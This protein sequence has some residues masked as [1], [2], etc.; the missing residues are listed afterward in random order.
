MKYKVKKC[1]M[2]VESNQTNDTLEEENDDF[3]KNEI[4][5]N[6]LDNDEINPQEYGFMQGYLA[7]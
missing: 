6:Y 2:H 7:A 3:Y 1:C 5:Q 4:L